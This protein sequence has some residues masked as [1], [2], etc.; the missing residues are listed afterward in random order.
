M[1]HLLQLLDELALQVH[2][3]VFQLLLLVTIVRNIVVEFVHFLLQSFEVDFDL[4]YFLLEVLVAFVEADLLLLHYHLL[5]LKV[6]HSLVD[7]LQL[8]VLVY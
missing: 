4:L 3:L 8:V 2:V 5:V 6:Y 7:L 1:L